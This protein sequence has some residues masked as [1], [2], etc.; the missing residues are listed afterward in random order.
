[1][2]KYV[3]EHII[4]GCTY[5]AEAETREKLMEK[6]DTHLREHHDLDHRDE[7]I[8]RALRDTGI[9]YIRQA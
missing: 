2:Y 1:M 9:Y 7:R 6:V 5:D 3:C 4:P 8:A